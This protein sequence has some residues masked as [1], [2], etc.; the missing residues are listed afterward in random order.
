MNTS[1]KME[2]DI[3]TINTL[4][5]KISPFVSSHQ[6]SNRRTIQKENENCT[7]INSIRRKNCK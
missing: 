3:T 5:G 1:T 6:L 2:C 4:V 7:F